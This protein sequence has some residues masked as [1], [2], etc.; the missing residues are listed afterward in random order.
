QVNAFHL[1]LYCLVTTISLFIHGRNLFFFFLVWYQLA[2]KIK[3]FY[4][5]SCHFK[6]V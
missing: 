1:L 6:D 5:I 3:I 4:F 2:N